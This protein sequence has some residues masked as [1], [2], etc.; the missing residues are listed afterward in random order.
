VAGGRLVNTKFAEASAPD[1]NMSP[2]L[3]YIYAQGFKSTYFAGGIVADLGKSAG[4]DDCTPGNVNN[5]RA[6]Y[7]PMQRPAPFRSVGN[8]SHAC[9]RIRFSVLRNG[10]VST[11]TYALPAIDVT[12]WGNTPYLAGVD[13]LY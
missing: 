5:P 6:I 9:H 12:G 8:V 11:K 4:T 7:T 2:Q 3:E 13:F 1:A 10:I